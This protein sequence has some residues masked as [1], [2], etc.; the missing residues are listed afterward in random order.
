MKSQQNRVELVTR[1]GVDQHP[2]L[3]KDGLDVISE[4]DI[5][6]AQALLGGEL[7]CSG[8]NESTVILNIDSDRS[9]GVS[10]GGV[11][12]SHSTLVAPDEGIPSGRPR[13]NFWGFTDV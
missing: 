13:E 11:S 12:A 6:V 3:R 4:E 1:P 5:S 10:G 7:F 8:L 9:E 2:T